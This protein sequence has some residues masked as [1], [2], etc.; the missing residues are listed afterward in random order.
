MKKS[1]Q[2]LA[3]WTASPE[4][5]FCV[6]MVGESA[7]VSYRK[8]WLWSHTTSILRSLIGWKQID[9]MSRHDLMYV[10]SDDGKIFTSSTTPLRLIKSKNRLVKGSSASLSQSHKIKNDFFFIASAKSPK[11]S[12]KFGCKATTQFLGRHEIIFSPAMCQVMW[13]GG[14]DV[15]WNTKRLRSLIARKSELISRLKSRLALCHVLVRRHFRVSIF[16]FFFSHIDPTS[17]HAF[18]PKPL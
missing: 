8:S 1:V 3:N 7:F 12:S 4:S 11:R 17:S 15:I 18:R 5:W 2:Q 13:S 10:Q 16:T 9:L 6:F 14:G